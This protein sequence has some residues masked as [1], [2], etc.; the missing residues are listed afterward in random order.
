MLQRAEYIFPALNNSLVSV[1]VVVRIEQ[2]TINVYFQKIIFG[3]F[4]T[5]YF[6]SF[7]QLNCL[8]FLLSYHIVFGTYCHIRNLLHYIRCVNCLMDV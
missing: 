1:F 8:T 6:S 5:K 2:K 4:A 3:N 7:V